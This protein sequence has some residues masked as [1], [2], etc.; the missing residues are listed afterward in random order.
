MSFNKSAPASAP[1]KNEKPEEKVEAA[2]LAG[3]PA[4]EQ[5]KQPAKVEPAIK[6]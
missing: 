6:A 3:K 1:S 5:N 2:P 4:T